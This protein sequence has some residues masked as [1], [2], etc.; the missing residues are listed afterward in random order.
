MQACQRQLKVMTAPPPLPGCCLLRRGNPSPWGMRVGT[1]PFSPG[2]GREKGKGVWFGVL[3]VSA[4]NSGE[5]GVNSGVCL[6]S[7]SVS[8]ADL[9]PGFGD[10]L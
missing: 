4:L 7:G 3:S 5:A 1:F 10:F 2:S 8:E 6:S 9:R